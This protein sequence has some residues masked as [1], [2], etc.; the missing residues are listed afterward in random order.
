MGDG[1]LPPNCK[2]LQ[3]KQLSYSSAA[4]SGGKKKKKDIFRVGSSVDKSDEL[5]ST[6][7]YHQVDLAKAACGGPG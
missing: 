3:Y 5:C 4:L 7:A 6:S 1:N 2:C